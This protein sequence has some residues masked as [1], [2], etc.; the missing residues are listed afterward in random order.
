MAE[1]S[2]LYYFL[3]PIDTRAEFVC[4]DTFAVSFRDKCGR[5]IREDDFSHVR[6][7]TAVLT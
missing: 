1:L 5:V 4:G 3:L 7:R 2:C 6:I